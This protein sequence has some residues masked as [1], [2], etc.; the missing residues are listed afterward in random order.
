MMRIAMAN[1]H[2]IRQ[3][4]VVSERSG[5]DDAYACGQ[6]GGACRTVRI[7]GDWAGEIP[8]DMGAKAQRHSI[9]RGPQHADI[10]CE[11][12]DIDFIH[13]AFA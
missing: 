1:H 13:P 11:S 8:Y 4:L 9:L 3:A 6:Q 5:V 10:A 7:R 2:G 12:A